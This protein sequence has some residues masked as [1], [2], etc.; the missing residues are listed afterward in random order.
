MLLLVHLFLNSIKGSHCTLIRART[1]ASNGSW[2]NMCQPN[3]NT[4]AFQKRAMT[5]TLLSKPGRKAGAEHR[6]KM[7][8]D[9]T[10]SDP[11]W[12]ANFMG[13]QRA[14]TKKGTTC[15]LVTEALCRK[16]G[17]PRPVPN[18]IYTIHP[19]AA[20][21]RINEVLKKTSTFET[22]PTEFSTILDDRSYSLPHLNFL[23]L[24]ES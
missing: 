22:S 11:L 18:I 5:I 9:I 21:N 12:N 7:Q 10:L 4:V 6:K 23:H 19:A 2:V 14:T 8:Q 16:R 3:L 15:S 20:Y 24:Y 13:P 17:Y 1:R